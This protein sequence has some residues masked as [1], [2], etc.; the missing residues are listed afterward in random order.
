MASWQNMFGQRAGVCAAMLLLFNPP[1]W[2]GA[3][4]N[5]VRVLLAVGGAAITLGFWHSLRQ[6]SPVIFYVTA[7]LVGVLSGFRPEMIVFAAPMVIY[8]AARGHR[9]LAQSAVAFAIAALTTAT[10]AAFVVHEV[11]G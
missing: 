9:T 4:S 2:F 1:F 5:Q 6:S 3:S 8:A 11:G 10:W 7:A